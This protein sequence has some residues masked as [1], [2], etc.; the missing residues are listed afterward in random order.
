MNI[1]ENTG[2]SARAIRE[3]I[4]KRSDRLMNYFLTAYFISGI[5]LAAFYDTWLIGFGIGGLCLLAY[6]SAKILLPGSSLYQYVLSAVFGVFMAQ[7]IYQV[8][9]LFEMHFFAFIGSA[10]LITYQQWKLQ[11]PIL[12]VVFLH[13]SLF[14]FLQ[15]SGFSTVY[16]TQLDYFDLQTYIIHIM[17]TMIIFFIC[18]LWAFQ[19]KKYNEI[20]IAQTLRVAEL[21]REAQLSLER[22]H[23][24]DMMYRLNQ[25]LE[26]KAKELSLSNIELEQFAYVASHDLQEP[27]RTV[28]SFL[29]LLE[30]KYNNLIDDKG[31]QYIAYTIDGARRMRRIINDLLEFSRVGRAED[32]LESVNLNEIMKEITSLY[33]QQITEEKAHVVYDELPVLYTFKAPLRQ[34]FQNLVANALKYKRPGTI[35]LINITCANTENYWQFS[36]TDNGIGIN[37]ENIDEIFIIFKRLHDNN[38]YKGTGI[39]LAITKKILENIGGKIWVESEEGKGSTFIFTL[40]Q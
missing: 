2:N 28:T 18:G 36:V 7:F 4:R 27:L 16:F 25:E 29:A 37:N 9:G 32:K 35:P 12:I 22:K 1:R 11:I 34:V 5:G 30:K 19:L 14:S 38:T 33:Q 40:P 8:H 15:D 24:A 20:H 26:A 13:H 6:Y 21:Q 10:I 39:G 31:K 3:E 17:L 23:N